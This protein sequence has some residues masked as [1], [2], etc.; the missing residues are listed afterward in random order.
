M[1]IISVLSSVSKVAIVAF[2]I[3]VAVVIYEIFLFYKKS[4]KKRDVKVPEFKQNSVY[5]PKQ[6]QIKTASVYKSEKKELKEARRKKLKLAGFGGGIL[7]L[8]GLIIAGGYYALN[9]SESQTINVPAAENTVIP[10]KPKGVEIPDF[11]NLQGQT[12]ETIPTQASVTPT[13]DVQQEEQTSPPVGGVDL[14]FTPS[15]SA[16]P[17]PTDVIVSASQ[18]A[19][20]TP[21]TGSGQATQLPESGIIEYSL[22]FGT[23]SI[24]LI[25]FAFVL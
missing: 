9:M 25:L 13:Q 5:G 21:S 18:T 22:L 24:G 19:T 1:D 11:G 2:V 20:P 8:V 15:A 14:T 3:T 10:T 12:G 16:S 23:V 17:V 7:V 6:H 4:E